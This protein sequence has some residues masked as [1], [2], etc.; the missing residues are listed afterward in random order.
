MAFSQKVVYGGQISIA[1]PTSGNFSS[2]VNQ[3]IPEERIIVYTGGFPSSPNSNT[4]T[5][6][7]TF[8]VATMSNRGREWMFINTTAF[9]PVTVNWMGVLGFSVGA[10]KL[11][12]LWMRADNGWEYYQRIAGLGVGTDTSATP[13]QFIVFGQA[14]SVATATYM[15]SPPTD[16]WTT[17]A[18]RPASSLDCSGGDVTTSTSSSTGRFAPHQTFH[19]DGSSLWEFASSNS[20]SSKAG[21]GGSMSHDTMV[22]IVESSIRY[23]FCSTGV[24]ASTLQIRRYGAVANS[25]ATPALPTGFNHDVAI[26]TETTHTETSLFLMFGTSGLSAKSIKNAHTLGAWFSFTNPPSG[27]DFAAASIVTLNNSLIYVFGGS[28]SSNQISFGSRKLRVNDPQTFT[29]STGMSAPNT[30]FGQAAFHHSQYY[31]AYLTAGSYAPTGAFLT[32]QYYDANTEAY[33]V[34]S[35]RA[36]TNYGGYRHAARAH[37]NW[38]S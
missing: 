34:Q 16:T 29:W 15:F 11:V 1:L 9:S 27:N 33:V 13:S 38:M 14:V 7:I 30:I 31:R 17:K 10:G 21:V 28:N 8:P 23:V 5:H 37:I 26:G 24:S 20:Y 3:A 2:T 12:K 25:W 19:V 18:T 4:Y 35:S 6:T 32:H 36:W 22:G